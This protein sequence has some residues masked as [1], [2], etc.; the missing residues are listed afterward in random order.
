[1]T[2]NDETCLYLAA[3]WHKHS[4]RHDLELHNLT[5]CHKSPEMRRFGFLT[6][7]TMHTNVTCYN[8]PTL[9]VVLN[10]VTLRKLQVLALESMNGHHP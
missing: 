1:M 6:W 4:G 8:S 7:N 5:Y 3:A 2:V 10:I 9:Y